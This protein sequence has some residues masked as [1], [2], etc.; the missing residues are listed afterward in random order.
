MHDAAAPKTNYT[1][2]VERAL[3]RVL[4]LR[5]NLFPPI[6]NAIFYGAL[7]IHPKYLVVWFAFRDANALKLAEEQGYFQRLQQDM[8]QALADEGYPIDTLPENRI[9]FVSEEEVNRAGGPW[10]YFH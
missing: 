4:K 7:E 1:V 5:G 8:L 6:T 10:Y 9:G 2:V 3:A